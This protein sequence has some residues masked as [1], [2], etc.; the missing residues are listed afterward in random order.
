[1]H[2][3][4]HASEAYSHTPPTHLPAAHMSTKQSLSASHRPASAL[5]AVHA[6][7]NETESLTLHPAA[8]GASTQPHARQLPANT[9]PDS[10]VPAQVVLSGAGAYEQ[11]PAEH[12]PITHSSVWQ[13]ALVTQPVTLGPSQNVGTSPTLQ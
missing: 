11:A 8:G 7:A 5:S 9:A 3:V 1:M 13:S 6:L 12:E 10:S 4:P 2:T